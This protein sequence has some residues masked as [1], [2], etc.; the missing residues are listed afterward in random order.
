MIGN[1]IR[2]TIYISIILTLLILILYI[3]NVLYSSTYRILFDLTND[4]VYFYNH[5][6]NVM[7]QLFH[8]CEK[9][10]DWQYICKYTSFSSVKYGPLVRTIYIEYYETANQVCGQLWFLRNSRS[11]QFFDYINYV[12][13]HLQLEYETKL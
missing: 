4:K 13:T 12:M 5:P 6:N 10:W 2:T 8:C 7:S 3:L 11:Q 9:Q 1:D